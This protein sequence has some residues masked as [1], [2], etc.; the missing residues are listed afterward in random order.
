MDM[1][2]CSQCKHLV[3]VPNDEGLKT[4]GLGLHK[5]YKPVAECPKFEKTL[6]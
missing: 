2:L 6:P 5:D 1:N 4:C 3:D